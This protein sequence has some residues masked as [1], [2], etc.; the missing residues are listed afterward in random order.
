MNVTNIQ[1]YELELTADCNAECPVCTRTNMNLAL[2]GNSTLTL[3]DIKQIFPTRDMIEGKN[4]DMCGVLGDPIVAPEC[5]EICRYFAENGGEVSISTN[6]GYRTADWWRELASIPGIFVGF[7]VDG[8]SETNH[9]YRVNVNWKLVERN[10]RAYCAAGGKG[11]W[12]YIVFEHNEHE[13]D[14]ARAL[15]EELGLKFR[16]RTG[17]RN[18]FKKEKHHVPRKGNKVILKSSKMF[19]HPGDMDK[20]RKL[21]KSLDENDISTINNSIP[22]ITCR[23]LNDRYAYISSDMRLWQCCYLYSDY[24]MKKIQSLFHEVDEDWNNL[25][26]H[27]IDDILSHPN[28]VEIQSMWHTSHDRFQTTCHRTCGTN[29]ANLDI[30][31]K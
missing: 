29:G 16:F 1:K 26:T 9:I 4:F 28:F 3:Q 31:H 21:I 11:A 14:S 27:T 19:N 18:E 24:K 15:A 12:K 17:G 13:V 22:S 20:H 30:T 5:L 2:S 25:Q 10:M 6:A 7:A 23:H 8:F